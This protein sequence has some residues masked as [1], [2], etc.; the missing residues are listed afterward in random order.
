LEQ[1]QEKIH[2]VFV[3]SMPGSLPPLAATN[4]VCQDQGSCNPRYMRSTTYA[5]PNSS[6]MVKQSQI[7]IA[8]SI[9]PL[10]HIR[11]DEVKNMIA[12][13]LSGNESR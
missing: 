2:E 5:I 6:D 10:A 4:F 3:T 13:A 9:S 12:F 8:L 7:P 1:S 11:S